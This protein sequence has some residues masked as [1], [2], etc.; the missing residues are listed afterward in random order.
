MRILVNTPVLKLLGGVPNHYMGLRRFW[1][2][3][4]KYNIIGKRRAKKG[5]GKYWLPLDVLKFMVRLLTFRPDAVLLNPSL[6][7]TALKRDFLFQRVA[8]MLGFKTALFI[9]GFNWDYAKVID[10]EWAVRNF[11][12][13][14]LIFVL[15]TAFREEMQKWGVTTPIALSTTKVD[16]DLLEGYDVE[17]ERDG[18]V[19]NILFLARVEKAKGVFI[20]IDTYRILKEKYPY[21]TLTIAGDGTDLPMVK[22]LVKEQ[23]IPDVLITG[24]VSGKEL[25]ETYKKADLSS[26]PSSYMEGMPTAVL[27]AMAFG[28][29][30]FTRCGNNGLSDFFEDGK[31]GY[32][33]DSL[34]AADFANAMIPYIESRELTLKVSRYNAKYAREHF[35]ASR[36]AKQI[37][38]EIK[39]HIKP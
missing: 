20:A 18:R 17:K 1:T 8:C 13:A 38:T 33:T 31:M 25:I 19:R 12:R 2:E 21:L 30:V 3:D 6:G 4:V 24:R 16:D 35:M 14:S 7:I 26:S 9:H 37:E 15:A 27:E 32:I 5:S 23:R 39:K 11:N 34:D 10:R 22:K 36:V 28:L 29:P